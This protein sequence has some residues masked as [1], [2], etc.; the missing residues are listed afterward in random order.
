MQTK[1]LEILRSRTFFVIILALFLVESVWIA[2]S[3]AFPMVFDENTHF[4]VIQFYS[5][6]LNPVVLQQPEH[7]EWAGSIIRNPSYLYHYL[8][9]FPYRAV[10]AVSDSLMVQVVTL[11]LVNILFFGGALVLF[12]RLLLKTNISP[13]IVHVSLLFF[14]LMPVVP[15]LAG[16]INYDNLVMLCAS[17]ALLLTASIA[18]DINLQRRLPFQKICFFL[19]LGLLGSLVQFMFLPVFAGTF[20]WLSWKIIQA[21]RSKRLS[22]QSSLVKSWRST[23]ALKKALVGIPLGLA[24]GLFL[25]MYGLN[26][27]MY[28]NLTPECDQVL[29]RQ[30]CA[31]FAPWQRNQEVLAKHLE[32]N[33][34]PA[35]FTVAWLYRLFVAMFFTSSGG[36]GP[37]AW[38]LSL[39]PLPVIFVTALTV[40]VIGALLLLVYRRQ[41]FKEYE[42]V[43][44]LLFMCLF[45]AAALWARN[46]QDYMQLGEKIAIQGRYLL[47]VTLPAMI[48]LALGFRRLLGHKAHLKVALLAA[49]F[50]LFLQGGG[51]LSYISNSTEDWYWRNGA[52]TRLNKAAQR[53]VHPLIVIKE[54]IKAIGSSSATAAT[55]APTTQ[56]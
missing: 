40:F 41:V 17:A 4:G 13:A 15:L 8:L 42:H 51:A 27:V 21:E 26:L 35:L 10:A 11:R 37:N 9:S 19:I 12:R 54:P 43:G 18:Q 3:A 55:V 50:V 30:E 20:L 31:Q 46:Y 56:D 29:T 24:A 49:T 6:R 5:H 1:I 23:S 48:I 16:Q 14:V 39:N 52:V 36:A 34:N 2:I 33:S 45:Y 38:Y 44:F 7:M 22:V 32:A 25:Q 53:V 47:P 28:H